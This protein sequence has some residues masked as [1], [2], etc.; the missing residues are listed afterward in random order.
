[1]V[2]STTK[3]RAISGSRIFLYMPTKAADRAVV[4]ELLGRIGSRDDSSD[5]KISMGSTTD[6][7]G[8]AVMPM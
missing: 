8:I 3:G 2:A 7:I 6:T 1:M 5:G 4:D